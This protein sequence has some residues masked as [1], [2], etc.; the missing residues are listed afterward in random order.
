MKP[1]SS[2]KGQSRSHTWWEIGKRVVRLSR[3]HDIFGRAAQLGYFFLLALFPALLGLT[4]VVGLL[5]IQPI[6]PRLMEYFHKVLPQESLFLVE[7]YLRHITQETG[8]GIFSLSLLGALVAASWGMMAIMETLNTVY[9]VKEAR[10]LWKAAV[11]AVLLA[12]GAA[13][14][15]IVSM[16]LILLGESLSLWI[17]ETVGLS[18]LFTFWWTILQWPITFFFMLIATSLIYYWAPNIHYKWQWI[19]PGSFLAVFLWIVVSLAFK[20]YV[21]RLMNYDVVY[22]SITGVIVLMIWLYLSGLALLIGG[23]LN[24]VLESNKLN[25]QKAAKH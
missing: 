15:V 14:F 12:T 6:L 1:A 25:T 5:P 11:T 10:S 4:G 22:G 9:N 23:E 21:E 16:T 7:D 19:A 2:G 3:Q 8:S 24:A 18:W 20:F 13:A 17:A